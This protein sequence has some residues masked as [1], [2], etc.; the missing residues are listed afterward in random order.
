MPPSRL[1]RLLVVGLPL[2]VALAAVVAV[3]LVNLSRPEQSPPPPPPEKPTRHLAVVII[4]NKEYDHIVGNPNAPYFNSLIDRG[5]LFT[6]YFALT[7]PSL[8]NYMTMTSKSAAGCTSDS[9]PTDSNPN[10]SLFHQMNTARPPISWRVYAEG[11]PTRC[12]TGNSGSYAVRHNPAPYYED[13]GPDGDNS[14]KRFDVPFSRLDTAMRSGSLP[15]FAMIIPDVFHDMHDDAHRKPCVLGSEV[16][17]EICQGD[18]WLRKQIPPLLSDGGDNDVTVFVLFDEG[19]T[20][21][22]GGGHIAAVEV[23][24][25][26]CKGCTSNETMNHHV[27]LETIEDWF[28]LPHLT[29]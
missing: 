10:E 28:H 4:E 19:E 1:R 29:D 22:G 3:V 24:P 26:V 7:H 14:C 12:A 5:K 21:R 25:N 13:I 2:L 15:R 9:C 16:Q 18:R 6:R 11:M 17:D 20:A 23:G 27:L 8:P